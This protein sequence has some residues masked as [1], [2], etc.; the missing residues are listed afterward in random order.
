MKRFRLSVL[1]R[2]VLASLLV[3]PMSAMAADDLSDLLVKKG[4]ITKEEADSVQ[5]RSIAS[6]IDKITMSGDFRLREE[7]MWYAGD[8]NDT[9]N[10]NRQRFRLRIGSDITEGPVVL[11]IR[12]ASGTGQQVSTNQSLQS[13]SSQK[14]IWI[15][16]A[17]VELKQIPDLTLLGGRMA[18]PFFV[19]ATG[20]LVFDDDYNP[21]GVAEQ[22]ALKMGEGGKIYATAGQIV[23]DGGSSGRTAQW[24]LGYQVGTEIKMDTT[25]I[26]LAVL[27]YTLANGNKGNFSQTVVQDGNTRVPPPVTTPPTPGTNTLFNPYN[28]VDATVSVTFNAGLPITISGDV[29][30]NLRDTVQTPSVVPPSTENENTGFAAGFKIG[31]A[32]AANTA[33]FGL[34]YRSVQADATLSDLADSDWGPNGGTNRVGFILWTAYNITK[35]SQIKVKAF[36]TKMKNEDLATTTVLGSDKNAT[37]NRVQVDYSVKF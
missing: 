15:D 17:Y 36:D 23:L 26:N 35:S 19:S 4:T 1:K 9:Q 30:K 5:K 14:A 8:D 16:R 37:F 22:Y 21:E 10:V 20:E 33:E 18:N 3:L 2:M 32:S 34:I 7:T 28:V 31:N 6:F 12:L 24:L 25:G 27:Y 11:H 13:L 29:V